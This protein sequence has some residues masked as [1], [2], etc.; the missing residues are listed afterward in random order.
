MK[1]SRTAGLILGIGVFAI[2][3][4]SLYMVYLQQGRE[5]QRLDDSL[6]LAQA[7]L[8]TLV[9]ERDDLESQL[10]QSES[11][12]AQA[13][14]FL[15]EAKAKFDE[16]VESIE[17]DEKLF[18]IAD[19]C[20]LEITKLTASEPS[21]EEVELTGSEASDE[22]VESVTYSIT[23]FTVEVE[24]T[25]AHIL[26]FINTIATDEYFINATIEL[27]KMEVP[28]PGEGKEK[29]SATIDLIIY[30]YKGE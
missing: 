5:Q 17:Y 27:V 21:D 14:S 11:E 9:S 13:Q 23:S 22:E 18:D 7:T 24:G 28:E 16:S 12:L 6:S 2:A 1:L 15:H 8:P 10:T 19:D 4:V 20:D 25:V 29:P 3:F 30:G 26:D